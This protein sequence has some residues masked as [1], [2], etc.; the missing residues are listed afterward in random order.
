LRPAALFVAPAQLRAKTLSV[1]TPGAL[2]SRAGRHA[3]AG[4][5][6]DEA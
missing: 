2:A 3:A 1:L 6:R 5:L 4:A